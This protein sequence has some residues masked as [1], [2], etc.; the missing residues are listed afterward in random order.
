[1]GIRIPTMMDLLLHGLGTYKATLDY[2]GEAE[3]L[4][5]I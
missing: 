5:L 3:P 2:L 4:I 1:M